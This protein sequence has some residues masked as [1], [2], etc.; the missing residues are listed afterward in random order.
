MM[1]LDK[2]SLISL[3]RIE[4]KRGCLS[5]IE[6]GKHIPFPIKNVRWYCLN[7]ETVNLESFTTCDR[8]LVPL[9]GEV[10]LIVSDDVHFTNYNLNSASIALYVPEGLFVHVS[11]SSKDSVLLVLTSESLEM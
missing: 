8:C 10:D 11:N 1:K 9:S 7:N 3:P 2:V 5:I 6:Q 4:D